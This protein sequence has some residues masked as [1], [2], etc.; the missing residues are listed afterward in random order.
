MGDD[1]GDAGAPPKQGTARSPAAQDGGLTRGMRA[2]SQGDHRGLG[3]RKAASV[4]PANTSSCGL[5][6]CA[7]RSASLEVGD[8]ETVEFL[9]LRCWCPSQT[10]SPLHSHEST[11][12]LVHAFSTALNHQSRLQSRQPQDP[13]DQPESAALRSESGQWR[14]L[15]F[16]SHTVRGD[17][18][19]S[20]ARDSLCVWHFWRGRVWPC[21]QEE[22][23]ITAL[24]LRR[25]KGVAGEFLL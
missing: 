1:V 11:Q 21:V 8:R 22:T 15:R 17:G 16:L 3:D 24:S 9:S 6:S 14:P 23:D 4:G 20:A 13:P 2:R 19:P 12:E 18:P 25:R 10:T 5:S 7:A